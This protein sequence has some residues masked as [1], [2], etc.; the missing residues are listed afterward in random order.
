M[1]GD[2]KPDVV[3]SDQ[4]GTT[5][6]LLT[7]TTTAGSSSPAFE[8]LAVTTG[9]GP[10]TNTAADVNGDGRPDLISVGRDDD[11]VS[12]LLNTQYRALAGDNS[13]TGTILG[14][15]IFANGFD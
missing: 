1:N 2:G 14:D 13:G 12:I 11:T 4:Q 6:T 5:A 3:A 10:Y 7:N 8:A 9:A 15:R